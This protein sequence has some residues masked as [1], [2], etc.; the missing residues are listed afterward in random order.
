MSNGKK[1]IQPG[2]KKVA[3]V[4]VIMQMEATECG[5]VC[6]AMI[7]AYYGKWMSLEQVRNDCGVSRDGS[8]AK[9][10]LFA[11][12]NYGMLAKGY[13]FEIEELK[14]S[15]QFPCIIHWNF[16]HF[17]VLDGFR[18]NKAII[19]DPARGKY[20]VSMEM[21]DESFT[22]VCLMVEPGENF[23]KEGKKPSMVSYAGKQLK[24]TKSVAFFV[25]LISLLSS[26]FGIVYPALSRVFMDHIL[27]GERPEWFGPFMTGMVLISGVQI[28]ILWIQA[29]SSLKI[30]GKLAAAG[31]IRFMWKILKMP[32]GFFAQ[33][34]AGDSQLRKD[35]NETIASSIINTFSPLVINTAMMFFY[36]FVMI[37]YSMIMTVIGIL[38]V[39]ANLI[40]SNIIAKK[41]VN[42]LRVQMQNAG[43]L[44]SATVAGIDMIESIK[45]SG[46]ENGFFE[47]WA[48]YQAGVNTGNVRIQKLNH[49]FGMIPK[50]VNAFSSILILI[51]GVFLAM[52]GR[53]SVGMI[54]AFQGFLNA[55]L[56]PAS[57]L[58][59]AGRTLQEMRS[60]I[61]RV[62]DVMNYPEENVFAE[63]EEKGEYHK[64]SG[65][66]EL[67]HVTFGYSRLAEPLLKD[68]SLTIK[69]GSRVAVVG[70]SGCGKSTISRL[71][72]GLYKP[73]SGEILFDGKK[74]GEIDKSVFN[75]SVTVIDQDI[76]LFEDSVADNI[77]MWDSSIED[78]EMIMAARDA[79]IHDVIMQREGGYHHEI[80][81]GGSNFSGGQRQQLEIARALAQDPTIIIMDEA[82]SALD[83]KTE[84]EVVN[85]IKDRGTTCIVIA[86]RLSTIQDCDEIIVMDEGKII[87]RGTHEELLKE[88]GM[89]TQLVSNE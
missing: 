44:A 36:L 4:P 47:R 38:S 61:E 19:N 8:S 64:L 75:A 30:Y 6:L 16:N 46:A 54:M 55:F 40:C 28:A 86:H 32:V 66:I 2:T 10:I 63:A 88:G 22:G 13:R 71:I 29:V 24:E 59:N 41:S 53:F 11:A 76:I 23:K 26:L 12:R 5:A 48:G 42:I 49:T 7:L 14:T 85:A 9:N 20:A 50:A 35:T 15:G 33:R 80:T 68:I 21:F 17:V 62:E 67:K 45:A 65:N 87:E 18:G 77:K 81:E 70:P 84:Y 78:F 43:K 56:A 37:K 31:N 74:M 52:H 58:I 34:S 3:K 25:V 82:T 79:Q 83:A 27:T 72:A 73:W 1:K 89:Y 39:V 60:N 57:T 51:T 69:S